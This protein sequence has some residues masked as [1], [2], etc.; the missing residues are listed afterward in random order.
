MIFRFILRT[1][2][3]TKPLVNTLCLINAE[4]MS[5]DEKV[6]KKEV[7]GGEIIFGDNG[8]P[9]V[10]LKE[11]AGTYTRSFLDNDKL[12]PVDLAKSNMLDIEQHLL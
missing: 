4:I 8:T 1:T 10:F 11:Q 9:T 2:K 3:D 5:A 6:L 12:F 7:R